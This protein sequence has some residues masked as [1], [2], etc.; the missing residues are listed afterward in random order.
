MEDVYSELVD[1][2]IW[3]II[4][5]NPKDALSNHYFKETSE[6]PESPARQFSTLTAS[7]ITHYIKQRPVDY[8]SEALSSTNPNDLLSFLK[9]YGSIETCAMGFLLACSSHQSPQVVKFLCESPNKDEGLLLY[10]S[11]V[12]ENIWS[13]DIMKKE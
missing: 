7:G 5:N 13:V 11:R 4:E 8:L 3:S 9:R 1:K 10:F 2:K 6:S 12:V